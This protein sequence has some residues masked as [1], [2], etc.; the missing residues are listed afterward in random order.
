MS[1]LPTES[2][3]KAELEKLQSSEKLT[4]GEI[5][6]A[7]DSLE[8]MIM[9]PSRLKMHTLCQFI[10]AVS[11]VEHRGR[12]SVKFFMDHQGFNQMAGG[13]LSEST[14]LVSVQNKDYNLSF[15]NFCLSSRQEQVE[16]FLRNGKIRHQDIVPEIHISFTDYIGSIPKQELVKIL[17]TKLGEEAQ[18]LAMVL[19]T[20]AA[21]MI[22]RTLYLRGIPLSKF[23]D[24]NFRTIEWEPAPFNKNGEHVMFLIS[25]PNVEKNTEKL[26]EALRQTPGGQSPQ[27]PYRGGGDY[28]PPKA[29]FQRRY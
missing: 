13:L 25:G 24:E 29:K 9:A 3:F 1:K 28:G 16:T 27:K 17:D 8:Q 26:R 22:I 15:V 10:E 6:K 2:R 18:P 4:V 23:I 21:V 11:L 20:G 12:K 5:N 19:T 14:E 7:V